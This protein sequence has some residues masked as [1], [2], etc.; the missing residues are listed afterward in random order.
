MEVTETIEEERRRLG[1]LAEGAFFGE[2]PVRTSRI[3]VALKVCL[4][5]RWRFTPRMELMVQ[6]AFPLLQVL[7]WTGE[8]GV[9]LR[10]RTVRAVSEVELVYLTREDVHSVASQYMELK[11]R[12]RRFERGGREVTPKFLQAIDLTKS[13]VHTMSQDFKQKLKDSSD[14][15]KEINLQ[16]DAFVLPEFL[17]QHACTVVKA[18]NRLLKAGALARLKVQKKETV[19]AVPQSQVNLRLM[20]PTS[21]LITHGHTFLCGRSVA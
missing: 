6:C 21:H 15:R 4:Q 9:Q 19:R 17:P 8:P 7:G 10:V 1:F 16:E 18:S 5:V 13:E 11:A 14:A 20:L 3:N 2:S 12:L